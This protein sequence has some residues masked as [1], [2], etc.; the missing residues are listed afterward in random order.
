[1]RISTS[2]EHVAM[3]EGRFFEALDILHHAG[4]DTVDFTACSFIGPG[5][6]YGSTRFFSDDWKPWIREIRAY[7]DNLGI[8][9]NQSHNL[10][11]NYFDATDETA[12]LNK[13]MDRVLEANGMLGIPVTVVHPIVPPG[14]D[15]DLAVCRR[16]NAAFFREKAKVAQSFGVELAVENMIVTKHFDGTEEWRYCNCPDQLIE[17]V[18]AI[19][20]QGV[21]FCFDVGHAHYMKEDLY[22]SVMRY[23]DRLISIHVHD[24][25]GSYDQHIL[26]YSG[27]ADWGRFLKGLADAGYNRDF[28]LESFRSCVRLPAELQT[29][30]M[31]QLHTISEWMVRQIW[32]QRENQ[33]PS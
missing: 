3:E 8:I 7:A 1:M 30:M 16:E 25:D 22:H 13:M 19:D 24:N 31:C 20:M 21:G 29:G 27:Q 9:F 18:D 33:P 4:F 11:Y 32:S 12:L 2:T 26:P 28:T 17:L 5:K 23:G 10:M 14:A 15:Y 6:A